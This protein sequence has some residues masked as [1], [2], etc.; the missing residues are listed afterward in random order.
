MSIVIV[1]RVLPVML[2]VTAHTR[3]LLVDVISKITRSLKE[4]SYRDMT[5][6]GLEIIAH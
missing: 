6:N 2:D 4:A 5:L 1:R 3:A